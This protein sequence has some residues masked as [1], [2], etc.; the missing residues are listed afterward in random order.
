MH[1]SAKYITMTDKDADAGFL[2]GTDASN[3][4]AT[5]LDKEYNLIYELSFTVKPPELKSGDLPSAALKL[6]YSPAIENGMNDAQ[7]LQPFLNKVTELVKFGTGYELDRQADYMQ[8]PIN[9][10][11]KVYVHQNVQE[12]ITN[13]ATAVQ[14]GFLSHQTASER[15]PEYPKNGEYSRITGETKEKQE[16]DLLIDL[17]RQDAQT[18]NTIEEQEAQARINHGKSG[19]DVNMAPSGRKRGRPN[20]FDTDKWGNR[21]DG[22]EHNWDEWDR[23]H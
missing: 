9:A 19:Q 1:G 10:W 21:T 22:S 18:E 3:A 23:R 13:I 7:A 14:N 15:C 12:E 8:L 6:L 17:E 5:Q 11:I 20:R 16:Q 2:D 4:F